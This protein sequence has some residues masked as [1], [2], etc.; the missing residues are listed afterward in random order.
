MIYHKEKIELA[1]IKDLTRTMAVLLEPW[2]FEDRFEERGSPRTLTV[3][4]AVRGGGSRRGVL[5]EPSV[6]GMCGRRG[7]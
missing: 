6:T 4:G 3:R 2:R 1:L 7:P 5:L